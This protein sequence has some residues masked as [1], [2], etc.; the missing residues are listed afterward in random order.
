M[1]VCKIVP[2]L[3]HYVAIDDCTRYRVLGLFS[4]PTAAHTIAFLEGVVEETPFPIQRVQTDRGR[5]SCRER[6][7]VG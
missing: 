7:G 5:E 6:A 1:D 4:R 2:G 3:Y